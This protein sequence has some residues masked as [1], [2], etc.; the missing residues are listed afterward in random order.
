MIPLINMI[1]VRE[2]SEV[3]IKFTQIHLLGIS[4]V[5]MTVVDPCRDVAL[6]PH[7]DPDRNRLEHLTSMDTGNPNPSNKKHH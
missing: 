7:E 3:V 2:N 1:P 6:S 5:R 4:L